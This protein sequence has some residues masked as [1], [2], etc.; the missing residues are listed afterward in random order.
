M[1]YVSHVGQTVQ[2][3]RVLVAATLS[4]YDTVQ[5]IIDASGMSV[6]TVAETSYDDVAVE[7]N[8]NE[9]ALVCCWAAQRKSTHRLSSPPISFKNHR[10]NSQLHHKWKN[11]VSDPRFLI[12]Q[13]KV[14]V[15]ILALR[16]L[17][18]PSPPLWRP[19][20]IQLWVWGV[21]Q[22]PTGEMSEWLCRV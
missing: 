14:H 13:H 10:K 11:S 2:K 21:S 1:D 4:L 9:P 15:P 6:D 12:R 8:D 20:A 19:L 18:S 7:T 22:A 17:P 16:C 3:W 5:V